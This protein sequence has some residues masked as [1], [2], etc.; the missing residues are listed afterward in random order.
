MLNKTILIGFV[1]KEPEI[2]AT[3]DGK[4]IASFSLATSES[5]K[6]KNGQR[7]E[8]TEWHR[9]VVFN[10]G[11]VKLVK[12]YI[13]KGSSLYVEGQIKSRKYKDKD[14]VERQVNEIVLQAYNGDIKILDKR[15]TS[16]PE[17]VVPVKANNED[18]IPW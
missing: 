1:G 4:E 16:N 18:S 15:E 8:N 17:G 14:G 11:L 10:P 2:R 3:T 13:H 5:W 9:I 7:Q 12:G 6:D